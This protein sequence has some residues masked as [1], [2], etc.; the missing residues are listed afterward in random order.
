MC[1]VN[2]YFIINIK[3]LVFSTLYFI[4]N[5]VLPPRFLDLE[6]LSGWPFPDHCLPLLSESRIYGTGN[7]YIITAMSQRKLVL[8]I[9][10][11]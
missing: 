6:F 5:L 2:F 8:C 11:S 1:N 4:I 10:D 7:R 9:D 3:C